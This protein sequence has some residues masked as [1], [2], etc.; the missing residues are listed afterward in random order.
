MDHEAELAVVIGSYHTRCAEGVKRWGGHIA[1]YLGDGVLVYF[2][3]PK[4]HE[5]DAERA[6]ARGADGQG[7][8][9]HVT[10]LG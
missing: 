8:R 9:G 6:A 5:D 7:E 3:Y 10:S 1:R 2:G 4:A